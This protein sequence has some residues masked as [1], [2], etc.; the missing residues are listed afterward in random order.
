M[1]RGS[2]IAGQEI[3]ALQFTNTGASP[4]L[5]AGYASVTLLRGGE[6]LG[7]PSQ[8]ASAAT[9]SRVLQ[10]GDVAESLLRNYTQNCQAP[11]SDAIHVVAPGMSTSTERPMQLR[12]CTLRVDPLGPP[13]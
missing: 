10:P 5:L 2:A 9:T 6:P 3:A 12:A 1:I 11:L 13:E 8:P 7:D 4:C